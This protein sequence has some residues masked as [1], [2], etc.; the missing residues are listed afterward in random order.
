[1]DYRGQT[2]V[3]SAI[4]VLV[5]MMFLVPAITEKAL[6]LIH[7]TV[8]GVCGPEGQTHSCYLTFYDKH[9]YSGKWWMGP[10]GGGTSTSWQTSG[11]LPLGTGDEKGWVQYSVEGLGP[12]KLDFDNPAVGSNK[13]DVV[14]SSAGT[15]H[16]G[17]GSIATFTY[18][19]RVNK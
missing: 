15:C 19:L 3:L 18:T 1:M 12:V 11:T 10:T 6:A 2:A 5:V 8:K 9:L 16:A 14:P 7:A 17:I 4:L 13:C